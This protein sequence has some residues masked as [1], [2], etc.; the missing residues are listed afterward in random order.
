[1]ILVTGGTGLVGSHLIY[2]LTLENN[3]IRAT[4]RADSDIERVKL[5]FKFY[6]KNFNQL[7]ENSINFFTRRYRFYGW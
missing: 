1:M 6:S 5:L 7:E 4:H 3:V 2:Q